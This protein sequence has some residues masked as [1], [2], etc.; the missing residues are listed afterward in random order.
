MFVVPP[1]AFPQTINN[2]LLCNLNCLRLVHL[3]YH[4]QYSSIHHFDNIYLFSAN[5]FERAKIAKWSYYKLFN[6]AVVEAIQI[7]FDR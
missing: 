3:R 7:L 1:Q 2:Q 6:F 4:E 5:I